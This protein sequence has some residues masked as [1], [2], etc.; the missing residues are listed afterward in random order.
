MAVLDEVFL[1][2]MVAVIILK[3]SIV[4]QDVLVHRPWNG[5][6][7]IHVCIEQILLFIFV[8]EHLYIWYV[9]IPLP[10]TLLIDLH[11]FRLSLITCC[12][13][14][15]RKARYRIECRLFIKELSFLAK[16]K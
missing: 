10:P 12:C 3:F 16:I 6:A 8:S 13:T 15:A 4:Y 14:L 7:A 9:L 5:K 1:E 11:K 2:I